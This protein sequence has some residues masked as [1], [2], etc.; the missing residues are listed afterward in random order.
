VAVWP[1]SVLMPAGG[2]TQSADDANADSLKQIE[3]GLQ[4]RMENQQVNGLAL[5]SMLSLVN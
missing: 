2:A 1:A 4:E 5:V 3:Q